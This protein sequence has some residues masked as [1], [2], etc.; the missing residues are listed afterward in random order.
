MR[1]RLI[2]AERASV[3]RTEER[4]IKSWLSPCGRVKV[5]H[6]NSNLDGANYWLAIHVGEKGEHPIH[7]PGRRWHTFRTREA[8][9]KACSMHLA[10]SQPADVPRSGR[11][12]TQTQLFEEFDMA[13]SQKKKTKKTAT[14]YSTMKSAARHA[15]KSQG[16]KLSALDAAAQVLA[17]AKAPMSAKELVEKMIADKL[18]SSAGKTPDATLYAAM[19]REIQAKGKDARFIRPEPGKF[20]LASAS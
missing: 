4:V 7:L 5:A 12:D 9:E 17:K 20:A 19:I 14:K 16:G 11:P 13:T 8:A 15:A 3:N 10:Q 6:I 2:F 18:W 1:E